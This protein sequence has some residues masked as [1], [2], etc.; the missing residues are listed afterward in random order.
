VSTETP[1]FE[2]R[3]WLSRQAERI[4]SPYQRF[5]HAALLHS[6]R[7]G[8][9]LF[10][11]IILTSGLHLPH[12][13]WASVTVL[14][15]IGGLQHVGTIRKKAAERAVGTMIGATAGL[16]CI[17]QQSIIGSLALT[18]VLMSVF[19]GVCAFYAIGRT[20]YM[21]LLAAITLC[22][23]AGHGDNPI[24]VGLWRTA[25]VMIGIVIALVFSFTLPLHATFSWR[26]GLAGNLRKGA[27][28]YRGILHGEPLTA[29]QQ[30]AAFADLS[31]GLV[32]LRALMPSTSK[33]TGAPLYILEDIQREHRTILSALEMLAAASASF[34]GEQRA[35]FAV[36]CHPLERYT[37]ATMIGM[38]I[39]LRSG[40]VTGLSYAATAP[41]A[42]NHDA[43]GR[44]L[45]EELDGPY[46]LAQRLAERVGR[47]RELLSGF[48]GCW[49][50]DG[51]KRAMREGE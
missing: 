21:A 26:Y 50:L 13:L 12:G 46:W 41:G 37:R 34:T 15:V 6:V 47:L 27:R 51:V 30:I 35:L 5:R 43:D 25:N 8:V 7:V 38:A 24:D 23:V 39:A 44:A 1:S 33:E 20:G 3:N 16:L 32:T 17:V 10:A 49:N 9:A 28:L 48:N 31:N 2:R 4:T 40:K 22:I 29:A 18:Y 36:Y 19:A 42:S 14:V 45:P 11:S